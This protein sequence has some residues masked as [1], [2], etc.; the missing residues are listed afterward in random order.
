MNKIIVHIDLNAFF[1]QCEILQNPKL[2]GL[3][4]AIGYDSRRSVI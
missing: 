2:K 3:P 1:V 4:V